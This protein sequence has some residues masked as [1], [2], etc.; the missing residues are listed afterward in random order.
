[1]YDSIAAFVSAKLLYSCS[2]TSSSFSDLKNR[3]MYPS[4]SGG[5]AVTRSLVVDLAGLHRLDE[6][7]TCHLAVIVRSQCQTGTLNAI[8]EA[9]VQCHI[10]SL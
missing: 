8:R 4:V 6:P 9:I 10:H 1:M 7:S 2:Q 5:A 3:S